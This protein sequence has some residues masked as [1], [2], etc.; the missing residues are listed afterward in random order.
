MAGL[1]LHC[2]ISAYIFSTLVGQY[3]LYSTRLWSCWENNFKIYIKIGWLDTTNWSSCLLLW[4]FEL[5][6]HRK[7]CMFCSLWFHFAP[8]TFLPSF[9]F[10]YPI[11]FTTQVQDKKVKRVSVMNLDTSQSLGSS[12]AIASTSSSKTPLPNGGCSDKFNC[13]NTNI[14]FPPGGCPSLRLPVVSNQ[15]LII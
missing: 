9:L 3:G 1:Y 13:L 2:W 4:L 11:S 5:C 8:L 6:R 15:P 14:S 12:T 7:K 10:A